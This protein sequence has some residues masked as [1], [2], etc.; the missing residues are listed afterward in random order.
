MIA[1][2]LFLGG[3]GF[4]V[5]EN[6]VLLGGGY[7]IFKEVTSPGI[8][9]LL[10]T[11]AIVLGDLIL[12]ATAYW[13]F[14]RPA[15]SRLLNRYVGR[16]RVN[17]YRAAISYRGGW[18]LFL[19]RF[20]FGIRAVAYVAAGAAHYPWLRFIAVDSLSVAIQ[21]I[22]FV[23]IGYYA[24]EKVEWAEASG[25]KI[26]LVLGVLVLVIIL[27]TW[28]SSI[29]MKRMSRMAADREKSPPGDLS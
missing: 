9:L 10:W 25:E 14:T 15:I 24:G 18:M 1:L 5:P 6:P 3:L 2:T 20:T 17:E 4:P 13:F 16:K 27:V 21:V 12:F 7:A 28:L 26:T 23:S 8:S 19:A 22:L 11:S 29:S